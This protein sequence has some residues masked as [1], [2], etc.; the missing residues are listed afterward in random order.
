MD[1]PEDGRPTSNRNDRSFSAPVIMSIAIPEPWTDRTRSLVRSFA[2]SRAHKHA[3]ANKRTHPYEKR[4][5]DTKLHTITQRPATRTG[6]RVGKRAWRPGL[7]IIFEITNEKDE[8][9]EDKYF[10]S[11]FFL[12]FFW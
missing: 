11:F 9:N 12:L 10:P 6:R 5:G 1:H 2:R 8:S 7:T 3:Y 4:E